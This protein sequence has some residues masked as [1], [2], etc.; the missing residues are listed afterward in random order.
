MNVTKVGAVD[1]LEKQPP[2]SFIIRPSSR[3]RDHLNITWKFAKD[4]PCIHIDVKQ[5]GLSD[6]V[7]VGSAFV[8]GDDKFEDLDELIASYLDPRIEKVSEVVAFRKYFDGTES[9]VEARLK[10][11]RKETKI[12]YCIFASREK[13]GRFVLAYHGK[14][15]MK[16]Y[17][18]VRSDGLWYRKQCFDR[19]NDVMS[20]FKKNFNKPI[21]R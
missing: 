7:T 3:G 19:P 17:I 21:P 9:E 1:Y 14:K 11:E 5:E 12:P 20:Y 10:E 18:M 6:S 4:I 8:V 15:M 16:E 2:G 13:V